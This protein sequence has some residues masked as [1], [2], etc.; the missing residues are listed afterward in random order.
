MSVPMS[1]VAAVPFERRPPAG[2]PLPIPRRPP[3][4]ARAR[5]RMDALAMVVCAFGA[6]LLLWLLGG[7][8]VRTPAPPARTGTSEQSR[9]AVSR[10]QVVRPGDSLWTI[11]RRARPDGDIRPVV[12]RMVAA[13]GGP[14]V[15][16]GERVVVP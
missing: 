15:L 7:F 11:A 5:L 13:R 9:P 6:G 3:P 14:T 10:V 16:V 4:G 1:Y 2:R 8:L 12:D